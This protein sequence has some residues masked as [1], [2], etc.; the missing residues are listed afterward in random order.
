MNLFVLIVNKI[1][2]MKNLFANVLIA[3]V[4]IV[5]IMFLRLA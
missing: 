5:I 1:K 2:I 3:A 4:N